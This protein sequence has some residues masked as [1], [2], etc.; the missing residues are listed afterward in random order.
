MPLGKKGFYVSSPLVGTLIFLI[1]AL[2]VATITTENNARINVARG[3]EDYSSLQFIAQAIIADSYNVFL[4]EKLEQIT[5]D[6]LNSGTFDMPSTS[7][8]DS[9]WGTKL[10]EAL[11]TTY[12]D[13]LG[14]ML[15]LDIK[16]YDKAY[17][18]MPG[19]KQCA[20]P[21]AVGESLSG[22]TL[23]KSPDESGFLVRGFSYGQ[24]VTCK[25]QDPEG[26]VVVDILGRY[27][28]INIRLPELYEVARMV[29]SFVKGALDM[30]TSEIEEPVAT[31]ETLRWTRIDKVKNTPIDAEEHT[32]IE[33]LISNWEG[34]MHNWFPNEIKRVVNQRISEMQLLGLHLDEISIEP[35]E[36]YDINHFEISCVEDHVGDR[37]NCLPFRTSI[38]LGSSSCEGTEPPKGGTNP[39]YTLG[40]D[41]LFSLT[42]NSAQCPQNFRATM[43]QILQPLGDVCIDYYAD[44]DSVYPICKKWEGKPKSLIIRAAVSDDNPKYQVRGY[45]KTTFRFMDQHPNVDVKR[46]KDH[47]LTCNTGEDMERYKDNTMRL[48]ENLQIRIGTAF[49]DN[50]RKWQDKGSTIKGIVDENLRAAYQNLYGKYGKGGMPIPCFTSGVSS[51]DQCKR[52][53]EGRPRIDINVNWNGVRAN[54]INRAND[55]CASWC[56]GTVNPDTVDTFCKAMFPDTPWGGGAGKLFCNCGGGQQQVEVKILNLPLS[57]S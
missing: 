26:E 15:G 19:I 47:K 4:Q 1:S 36:E 53:R 40:R 16:A 50:H 52:E 42:C 54:C 5:E 9:G 22:L 14:K 7:S 31:W 27:Y 28:R 11:I 12:L 39:F 20:S 3:S 17:S 44:A 23:E 8:S 6:F 56:G 13:K 34:L 18:E 21:S 43:V 25:S 2:I 29:I 37:R 51:S 38:L 30:G 48:L 24:M 55:L 49:S 45:D 41:D 10:R 46:V 33:G 35:E 32:P 57:H